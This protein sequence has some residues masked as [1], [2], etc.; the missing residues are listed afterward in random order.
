MLLPSACTFFDI[1]EQR[2]K[3]IGSLLAKDLVKRD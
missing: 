1:L 3:E 2:R